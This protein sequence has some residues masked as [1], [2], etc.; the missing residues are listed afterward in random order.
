[1]SA[2]TKQRWLKSG[3]GRH[4]RP[5]AG[6]ADQ[7]IPSGRWLSFRPCFELALFRAAIDGAKGNP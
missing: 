4:L 1:M 7:R 2:S 6:T 3:P 5:P